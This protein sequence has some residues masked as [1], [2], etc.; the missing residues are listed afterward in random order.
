MYCVVS[1]ECTGVDT[2]GYPAVSYVTYALVGVCHASFAE[3][4]YFHVHRIREFIHLTVYFSIYF[5]T[6]DPMHRQPQ[7][8][9]VAKLTY[10]T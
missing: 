5:S 9:F 4:F 3:G 7:L 10:T 1:W 6:S 8:S 2:V